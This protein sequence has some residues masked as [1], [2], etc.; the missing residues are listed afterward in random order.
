MNKNFDTAA[1]GKPR[2]VSA[3]ITNMI[4]IIEG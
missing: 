1:D 2:L 3:L 4:I